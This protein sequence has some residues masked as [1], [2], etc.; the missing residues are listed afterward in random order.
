MSL[1]SPLI[2]QALT[3]KFRSLSII[4]TSERLSRVPNKQSKVVTFVRWER[5]RYWPYC[6]SL[7]LTSSPHRR[8]ARTSEL[9]F[10]HDCPASLG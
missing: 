3:V 9:M 2:D 6:A 1:T 4:S 7:P 5:K 10:R 8:T